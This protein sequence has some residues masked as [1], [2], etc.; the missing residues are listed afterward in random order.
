MIF[1]QF[2]N[3]GCLSYLIGDEDTRECVVIDP[4]KD[5]KQY[6]EA[7]AGNRLK[8]LYVIDTH[9]HADHVTGAGKLAQETGAM[10]VMSENVEAQ[11]RAVKGRVVTQT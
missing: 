9:S 10:L 8:P 6:L 3:A 1:S 7:M 2:R 4:A 11:R 5:I